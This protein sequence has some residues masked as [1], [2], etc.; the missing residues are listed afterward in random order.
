LLA[1]KLV[2]LHNVAATKPGVFTWDGHPSA[3]GP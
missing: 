1:T 2:L 3:N